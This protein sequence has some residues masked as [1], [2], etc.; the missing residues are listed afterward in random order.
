MPA[1]RPVGPAVGHALADADAEHRPRAARLPV[2]PPPLTQTFTSPMHGISVSYPEGWTARAA[3]EPWTDRLEL[4]LAVHRCRLHRRAAPTRPTTTTCSCAS[5]RSRSANP[6]PRTG[7]RSRWRA[8]IDAR[9]PSR[10]PSTAPPDSSAATT[11][12]LGGRHNRRPRLLASS[13]CTSRRRPRPPSLP[14]DRA[15]FEEVLATVQLQPE[16]AVDAAPYRVRAAVDD[17]RTASIVIES[18]KPRLL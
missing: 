18:V 15:W 3:T 11:C 5:P 2:S 17:R 10:S 9:P 13:L 6:R 1:D 4:A 16:D 12:H 7:S 8:T 14:Y